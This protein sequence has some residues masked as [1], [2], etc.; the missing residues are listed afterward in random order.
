MYATVLRY[1]SGQGAATQV[2]FAE[3]LGS[4]GA[5]TEPADRPNLVLS[6]DKGKVRAMLGLLPDG[7]PGLALRDGTGEAIWS[8]P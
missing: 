5:A 8:A 6:D 3:E 1:P 4:G 7:S 2:Q